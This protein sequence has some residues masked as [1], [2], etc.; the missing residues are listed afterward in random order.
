MTGF[1]EFSFRKK[2]SPFRILAY[3]GKASDTEPEELRRKKL[4]RWELYL[5]ELSYIRERT[6]TFEFRAYFVERMF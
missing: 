2:R 4:K 6:L 3:T 1:K 5:F